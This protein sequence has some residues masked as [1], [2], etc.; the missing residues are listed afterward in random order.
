MYQAL[1]IGVY[2][3]EGGFTGSRTIWNYEHHSASAQAISDY[4]RDEFDVTFDEIIIVQSIPNTEG[5]S[6]ELTVAPIVRAVYLLG[7]DYEAQYRNN[8]AE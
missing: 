8:S 4:L 1:A 2:Y 3:G 5:V 6:E 7:S